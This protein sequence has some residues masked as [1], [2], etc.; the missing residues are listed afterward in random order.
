MSKLKRLATLSDKIVDVDNPFSLEDISERNKDYPVLSNSKYATKYSKSLFLP[1]KFRLNG[2]EHSIQ[3]NFCINPFCKWFGKSQTRFSTVK[4]K[5]YRYKL[6]GQTG[7]KGIQCNC[8]PIYPNRGMTFNCT[9]TPYSNWGV[10]QE[11]ER[12]VRIGTVQDIEP[13]YYFHK[14]T[15]EHTFENPF[16]APTLFYKRGKSKTGTQ[17][18]QCKLCEKRTNMMPTR[19]M[20]STYNQKRND[21]LP[22]FTKLLV[23]KMPVSRAI[24]VM[25]IGVKTYYSK[26]EWVY[27]RCLEFL[28]RHEQ[29]TLSSKSLGTVWINTDK[30]IYY[31]NNVRKKGMGGAKYDDVEESQ[32]PT[33]VI[34]SADVFSRYVFRSDVAYDWDIELDDVVL[35]TVLFKEDHLHQFARKHAR[36]RFSYYP[37]VPTENDNQTMGEYNEELKRFNRREHYI[38][39]LH[40]NSTYTT[41][42]HY[43]LIKDLLKAQEWRFVTDNDSSLLSA[44]YRVF[45]EDFKSFSAHHF[46]CLT[47]RG[48]TRKDAYNEFKQARQ[49]LYGWGLAMDIDSRSPYTIAYH[50]LED[51][52]KNQ[53]HIFHK[54]VLLP[55]HRFLAKDNNPIIHPLASIDKGYSEVDC[56]TDLSSLEPEQ[57]AKMILNVNDHATNFFIQHIRRKLS[58]LERPLTTARGDGKSYIYSNFNPKYA[59]M[60][61][62][63]LRTYYNFCMP[64]KSADKKKL[65]PAQRLGITEKVFKIEDILYFR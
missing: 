9:A 8:D 22:L 27:R 37:Q 53:G 49:D 14:E 18:W 60:A 50:Y 4:Y 63:I 16:D 65:T 55:T 29:K 5:P 35:D 40:T 61:L 24:D 48:K 19:R 15:C 57:V 7:H 12:L 45:S 41:F 64:Y 30:M 3:Y 39:G 10:A 51:L 62:T 42:A 56:T 34:I 26:L 54:E 20:S 47:D 36:L 17:R 44:M 52:F 28:E 46:L 13:K 23:N 1:V 33:H 38:D 21:I 43:W 6:V 31:L 32:F 2:E 25:G 59:Q 11:V 58:I